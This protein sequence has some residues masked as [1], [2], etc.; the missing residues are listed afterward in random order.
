[1]VMPPPTGVLVPETCVPGQADQP[2]VYPLQRGHHA[3]FP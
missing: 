3:V 1:M 2:V